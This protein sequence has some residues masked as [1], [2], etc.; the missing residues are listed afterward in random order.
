ME[1]SPE[2][3]DHNASDQLEPAQR[4]TQ[5]SAPNPMLCTELAFAVRSP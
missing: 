5:R 2:K 1:V 4:V 3:L